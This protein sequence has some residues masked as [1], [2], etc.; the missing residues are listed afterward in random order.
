MVD[1]FSVIPPHSHWFCIR[2]EPHN[3]LTN[4]DESL[5][6]DSFNQPLGDC[7]TSQVTNMFDDRSAS[8]NSVD[9]FGIDP[10]HVD[11]SN[12]LP[13]QGVPWLRGIGRNYIEVSFVF[14]GIGTE[15]HV[16]QVLMSGCDRSICR[17]DRILHSAAFEILPRARRTLEA[18]VDG[19]G[20]GTYVICCRPR[21]VSGPPRGL[22][23][24]GLS[25]E[26]FS[27]SRCSWPQ[28]VHVCPSLTKFDTICPSLYKLVKICPSLSLYVQI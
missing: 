18:I 8:D 10:P 26:S 28:F 14:S 22:A 3:G 27:I 11:W 25:R 6:N 4:I 17:I 21:F 19:P 5:P 2:S 15:H 13:E 12:I 7:D 23:L 1:N 24:S 9:H 20:L 16:G